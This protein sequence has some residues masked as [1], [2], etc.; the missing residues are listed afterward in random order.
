MLEVCPANS[1]HYRWLNK[2]HYIE[3]TVDFVPLQDEEESKTYNPQLPIVPIIKSPSDADFI[4]QPSNLFCCQCVIKPFSPIYKQQGDRVQL[5]GVVSSSL[6]SF[7]VLFTRLSPRIWR[8][9]ETEPELR[10]YLGS[11]R[12]LRRL[13]HTRKLRIHQLSDLHEDN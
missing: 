6:P 13:V 1:D 3:I 8:L 9:D 12:R 4:I 7:L 10:V 5:K 2:C 11:H